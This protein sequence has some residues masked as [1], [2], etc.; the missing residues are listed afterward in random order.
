MKE[1]YITEEELSNLN[2]VGQR[3]FCCDDEPQSPSYKR[4]LIRP[5]I[6]YLKIILYMLLPL[7]VGVLYLQIISAIGVKNVWTIWLLVIALFFYILLNLKKAIICIIKIYQRYAPAHIRN[8]CR[9]E[10]SCSQY[11]I[12]AIKK[13][14][15]I[16][17]IGRGIDRLKR[18]NINNGG[19]DF[20]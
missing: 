13:H 10:P 1:I 8:K 11:M 4:A 2:E 6:N 5:N 20:P 12:L 16:K 17:G 15:L 9:F 19:Y 14:G 18:C 7:V 3:L